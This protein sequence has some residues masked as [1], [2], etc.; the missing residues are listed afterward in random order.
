MS[1]GQSSLPARLSWGQAAA[2]LSFFVALA[3]IGLYLVKWNPYLHRVFA[4]SV[5]HTLGGSI[6]SGLAAAPPEPS[7]RAAIDY[8]IAYFNAIWQ[9]LVLGLLLAA[10]VESVLP[11]RWLV[12]LLGPA[13]FRSTALGGVA[14]LPGMM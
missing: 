10:T 13:R 7:V 6:V 4:V 11:T 9:A 14:A 8:S 2:R 3:V 5:S 12:N 1:V